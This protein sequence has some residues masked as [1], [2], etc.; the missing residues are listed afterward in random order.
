MLELLFARWLLL[1]SQAA[2]V[3]FVPPARRWAG[4]G[5]GAGA[6]ILA[7]KAPGGLL[8]PFPVVSRVTAVNRGRRA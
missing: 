4:R 8:G 7:Y 1:P 3:A 5:G 2:P 6:V